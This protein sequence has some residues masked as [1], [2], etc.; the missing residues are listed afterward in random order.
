MSLAAKM[1]TTR[2][3][4]ISVSLWRNIFMYAN[5]FSPVRITPKCVCIVCIGALIWSGLIWAGRCAS[6]CIKNQNIKTK[7][8]IL[9]DAFSPISH[10]LNWLK[11]HCIFAYQ[12]SIVRC[13]QLSAKKMHM[14]SYAFK[15]KMLLAYE[16]WPFLNILVLYLSLTHSLICVDM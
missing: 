14:H 5:A 7:K 4:V 12:V 9:T 15:K 11:C 10:S 1:T 6:I 2:R 16:H 13:I 8:A 3:T